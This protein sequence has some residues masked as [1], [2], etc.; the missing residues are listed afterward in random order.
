M[1]I[2]L[3]YGQTQDFRFSPIIYDHV[4]LESFDFWSINTYS[5]S[6]IQRSTRIVLNPPSFREIVDLDFANIPRSESC[7]SR[8]LGGFSTIGLNHWNRLDE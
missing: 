4:I 8:K 6:P 5:S 7:F 1:L 3:V 2:N